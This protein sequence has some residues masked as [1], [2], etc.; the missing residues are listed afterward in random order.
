MSTIIKK[1]E[2][3]I[4]AMRAVEELPPMTVEHR[5]E[6]GVI[7]T[8]DGTSRHFVVSRWTIPEKDVREAWMAGFWARLN[9]A[10]R[11][12]LT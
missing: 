12:G 7:L 3:C 5:P 1:Y 10:E 2:R 8:T 4:E 6:V 11:K 9:R